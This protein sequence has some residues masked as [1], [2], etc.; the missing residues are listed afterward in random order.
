M[1]TSKLFCNSGQISEICKIEVTQTEPFHEK[2]KVSN[3]KCKRTCG[4]I[5]LLS[6]EVYSCNCSS[7]NLI[8]RSI[9]EVPVGLWNFSNNCHLN[10]VLQIFLNAPDLSNFIISNKDHFYGGNTTFFWAFHNLLDSYKFNKKDEIK[11]Y[12]KQIKEIL[13]K[14]NPT[15]IGANFQAECLKFLSS[16]GPWT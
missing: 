13:E 16:L 10:S 6:N 11:T 5:E 8:Q 1:S 14:E 9:R 7:E 15:F 4:S 2:H 3:P 12:Q